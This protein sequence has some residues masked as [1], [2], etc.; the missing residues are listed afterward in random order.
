MSGKLQVCPV[1]GTQLRAFNT[2]SVHEISQEH[3]SQILLEWEKRESVRAKVGQ[4]Y[5]KNL[6]HWGIFFPQSKAGV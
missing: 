6:T 1:R 3:T 5:L 2:V 4:R